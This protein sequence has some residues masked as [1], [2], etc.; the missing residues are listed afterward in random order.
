MLH[1][2][3]F[4]FNPFQEQT[5]IVW[6]D[7]LE[8]VIIDPGCYDPS[9][10]QTL[11]AFISSKQLKPQ[12]V[13]N[14]HCHIDHVLGNAFVCKT[15]DIPLW[16]PAGEVD[17]LTS[18]LSYG[19]GMGIYPQPSPQPSGLLDERTPMQYLGCVWQVLNVPG[20]S[21]DGLCFYIPSE[22]ILIAGDV[23]FQGS[24]GRT[25]LP[26]G[27]YERLMTG[28]LQK[29]MTLPDETIVYPGHGPATDIVTERNTNPFV[30][31]FTRKAGK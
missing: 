17:Q 25:D 6:N 8:A 16:I 11:Q 26:G 29:L 4:T 9:E 15:W 20:H 13:L 7:G 12:V 23:L 27:N 5:Y 21:P 19:P 18:V 2:Q 31:D 10:Q 24:I 14:T 22:N 3:A 1:I 28:I 30:L